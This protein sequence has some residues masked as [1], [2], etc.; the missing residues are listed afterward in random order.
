[1]TDTATTDTTALQPLDAPP[2]ADRH[3]AAIYLASLA[4]GT[5]RRGMAATLC[6]VAAVFGVGNVETT[7]GTCSASSTSPRSAPRWRSSSPPLPPTRR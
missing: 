1:M 3:P 7:R 2:P 6:K 5:G 4:P